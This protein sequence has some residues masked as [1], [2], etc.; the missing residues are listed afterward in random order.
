MDDKKLHKN[1]KLSYLLIFVFI[2]LAVF[3]F[4]L[5]FLLLFLSVFLG[6]IILFNMLIVIIIHFI[7]MLPVLP[8]KKLKR[9]IFNIEIA[10]V[11]ISFVIYTVSC[12]HAY[13]SYFN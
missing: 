8:Q 12:I 5:F 7:F 9:K 13:I 2:I 1:N 10:I 11:I 4:Y 6:D 3:N